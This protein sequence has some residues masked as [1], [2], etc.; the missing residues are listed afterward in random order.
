MRETHHE[1]SPYGLTRMFEVQLWESQEMLLKW[2]WLLKN[3]AE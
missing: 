1:K 3:S 2:Q